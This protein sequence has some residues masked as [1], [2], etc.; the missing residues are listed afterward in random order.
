[1][2]YIRINSHFNPFRVSLILILI[3]F[4]ITGRQAYAEKKKPKKPKRF[5]AEF[6]LETTYDDNILKY[7]QKYL[8]RFLNNE[9]EGRFHIKTYDDIILNPSLSLGT[10]FNIFKKR[11]TDI[12]FKYSYNAY[13][14]ND[15]KNWSMIYA[16]VEQN[17][18]KRASF[19]FFY[20]YIPDFYV[21]HFR[22]EDWKNV[23]GY[24]PETFVPFSFAKNNYGFWIQNTFLKS[25]RIR[26]YFYY[27]QYFHNVHFTE[28]DCDN[29]SYRVQVF[30]K[31][32]KK[33]RFDFSWEFMTS[34]AKG[35]DQPGE[36]KGTS[37]DADATNEGDE[38]NLG[39]NWKLPD[40]KKHDN[41]LD[42]NISFAK[43]Y[44]TTDHYVEEDPEH[45]GRVD[46]NFDFNV[47]Y[48]FKLNKSMNLSAYYQW[49]LRD[50][51]TTS[52][53]NREYVSNEKDYKQG[54]VG[55]EFAWKFKF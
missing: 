32:N 16:G 4:L 3:L 7:S 28:Y 1:M 51:G 53:Y 25:T 12:S 14:V 46:T 49:H 13:M 45:A 54:Q 24:T 48:R 17:L 41:D 37:D 10:S 21:R 47:R 15:I 18:T 50:S 27:G 23:Y 9:D 31:I 8:D 36:T 34:D 11:S 52:D 5:D 19:K 6:S 33:L 2:K 29:F 55:L 26:F 39:L 38:F 20:T 43:R 44:Y 30:Q 22:D 42:F 35:Y 40:I